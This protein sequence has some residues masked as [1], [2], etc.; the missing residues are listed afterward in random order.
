MISDRLSIFKVSI[1]TPDEIKY[2]NEFLE[3]QESQT[4]DVKEG[5]E[6]VTKK[7]K[8]SFYRADS[9]LEVLYPWLYTCQQVNREQ[10]GYHI[11]WDFHLETI[12]HNI[13]EKDD[14]Y[15]WHI[16]AEKKS[17]HIDTKLTCLLNISN[18]EYEGGK[19]H[20][21]GVGEDNKNA[22]TFEPGSALVFNSLMAHKVDPVTKGKRQTLTYWAK[23]PA[24]R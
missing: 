13:Y 21:V 24:W 20:I 10:F 19:F 18:E 4:Q 17:H 12:N 1:Y 11:Y 6:N 14:M 8:F 22:Y 2:I 5:A 7:G 15:D 23:G 3:K 9:L 16:D